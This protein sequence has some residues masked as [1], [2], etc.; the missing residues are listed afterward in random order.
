M[1]LIASF[2]GFAVNDLN[3]VDV[4]FKASKYEKAYK[5][6]YKLKGDAA[7]YKKS[8]T[9]YYLGFSLLNLSKSKAQKLGISNREKSIVFNVGK[10]LAFQKNKADMNRFSLFSSDFKA[11]AKSRLKQA[12]KYP[13]SKEWKNITNML[14]EHFADTVPEY[15][16]IQQKKEGNSK[17]EKVVNSREPKNYVLEHNANRNDSIIKWAQTYIGT[18]Y[19]WAGETRKG[20]D[21]SGFTST[22]L[23]QFGAKV[24]HSAKGQAAQGTKVKKYQV[25][26]IACFG[27]SSV[28]HVAVVI[29]NYPEP[30][31]VIHSTTSKGVREDG[32]ES[33]T[34]WNPKLLYIVRVL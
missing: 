22:V 10:G 2:T 1:F 32:I 18:P 13:N 19:L 27:S 11:V 14:A 21:C 29:S 9:Y 30:L 34:Y 4:L 3:K 7:Y 33:S 24:P 26:D 17:E 6:A 20:V 12:K 28:Y 15:W 8:K 5:K 31:R 23:N 25:G 16:E